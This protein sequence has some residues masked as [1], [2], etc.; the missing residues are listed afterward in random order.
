MNLKINSN[1]KEKNKE[2]KDLV[3]EVNGNQNSA[4]KRKAPATKNSQ[5]QKQ[6][7]FENNMNNRNY[8]QNKPEYS[9]PLRYGNTYKSTGSYRQRVGNQQKKGVKD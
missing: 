1:S 9:T 3:P 2:Y 6:M 4:P 8:S 7:R 5:D